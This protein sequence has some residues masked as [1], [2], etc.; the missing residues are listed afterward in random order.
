MDRSQITSQQ[1]S[2]THFNYEPNP[3]SLATLTKKKSGTI[4]IVYGINTILI[5]IL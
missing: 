2:I 1:D 4:L 3:V 5:R